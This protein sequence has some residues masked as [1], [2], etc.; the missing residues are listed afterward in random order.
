AWRAQKCPALGG[1]VDV[2]RPTTDARDRVDDVGRGGEACVD[3]LVA[4]VGEPVGIRGGDGHFDEVVQ[5][6]GHAGVSV[7][8]RRLMAVWASWGVRARVAWPVTMGPS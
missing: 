7:E 2:A 8:G 1:V 5:G 3:K 4:K 6:V